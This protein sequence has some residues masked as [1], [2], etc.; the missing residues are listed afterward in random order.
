MKTVSGR[1][2]F[3]CNEQNHCKKFNLEI[4]VSG[5]F[6]GEVDGFYDVGRSEFNPFVGQY[7]FDVDLHLE[8][9]G[10]EVRAEFLK[11]QADGFIG[12]D[13]KPSL[14]RLVVQGAYF[15]A[16]YRITNWFGILG[17]WDFRDATHI[18]Y[19]VPFAYISTIWR[20]TAGLRFDINN[21]VAFKAEFVHLQPFG[22]MKDGLD[23]NAAVGLMGNPLAGLGTAGDFAA[24]YVTTSLV[25]RY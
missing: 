3:H 11:S 19:S 20:V 24:D 7:T 23:D 17:R 6:G 18:D 14:P 21:N 25:L 1:L 9:K 16:S 12:S 15:E 2:A 13:A 10:L 5:E 4:G 8:Y 22:R